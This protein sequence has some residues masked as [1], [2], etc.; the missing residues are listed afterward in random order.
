MERLVCLGLSHRTAPVELRERVGSLGPGAER[1]PAV[2]EH[3]VLDTCYRVELYAHLGDGVDDAR[4]EL[5]RALAGVHGVEREL[6]VDHLYV[7][8]GED[9]ARQLG[10]V[11]AGL[12]SLVLGEAE[13]LGQVRG[14]HDDA[15][16]AGSLG[17][18]LSLLFRSA[19]SAGRRARSETAIGANPATASSMAL[20]LAQ[21]VLGGLRERRALVVGAGQIGL[22]SMKALAG[23]GIELTAVANRTRATAEEVAERFGAAA[24]GLEELA[25]ALAWADVVVTATSS[26]TPVVGAEIVRTAL[27]ERAERPLVIVDLAVPADV[28]RVAGEIPGVRLFD[29]DDLRAGLDGAMAARLEEVPKVEAIVEDEVTAFARRYRELE[30]EPVVVALRRQA[31][32]IR[33]RELERTLRDLGELSPEDAERVEH[34]TRALVKKLMHE[35]TVRLRERAGSGDADDVAALARD[36]FG[37]G[38]PH[39][40]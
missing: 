9:V 20:A 15:E 26:E 14:S 16:A 32:E 30:V 23:R 28:E 24:Y 25:E 22:Q 38:A 3:A 29:V 34:L 11:A 13:I 18:A 36:L 17:P 8:A 35:P 6:L 2:E 19:I 10:R 40:S 21:G 7:H 39:E 37:L 33:M 4:D 27:R 12:D 31:E 1:C 5:I